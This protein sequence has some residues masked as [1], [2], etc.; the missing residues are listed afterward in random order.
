MDIYLDNHLI[1]DVNVWVVEHY[2]L[3]GILAAVLT[4]LFVFSII[5]LYDNVG[6]DMYWPPCVEQI[7]KPEYLSLRR[8]LNNVAKIDPDNG[9]PFD[10]LKQ[11]IGD[12]KRFQFTW[13]DS[14]SKWVEAVKEQHLKWWVDKKVCELLS[15]DAMTRA[16]AYEII[17]DNLAF[18]SCILHPVT[19]DIRRRLY[20]HARKAC[21]TTPR[22][23]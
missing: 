21:R 2:A 16:K 5:E 14:L 22:N 7:S 9:M 8:E 10:K 4:T 11:L 18:Q 19:E 1:R 20:T 15:R 17:S 13:R 6:D 23:N 3:A 12:P